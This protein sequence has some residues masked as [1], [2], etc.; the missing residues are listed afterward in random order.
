[1]ASSP[2]M[3]LRGPSR[4]CRNLRGASNLVGK[5][6][7]VYTFTAV[8]TDVAGDSAQAVAKVTVQ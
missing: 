3:V 1:M 2:G 6:G 7:Q 4:R 8:S 5:K